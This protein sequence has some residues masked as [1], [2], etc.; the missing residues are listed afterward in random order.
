MGRACTITERRGASAR[1]GAICDA[2]CGDGS[3][4]WTGRQRD[5]PL[6]QVPIPVR[7]RDEICAVVE[8]GQKRIAQ[9]AAFDELGPRRLRENT[10]TS[11]R[12]SLVY[13]PEDTQRGA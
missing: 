1:Q 7:C 11:R 4:G 12:G 13:A 8:G 3:R 10:G 5:N 9:A 2:S 6:A